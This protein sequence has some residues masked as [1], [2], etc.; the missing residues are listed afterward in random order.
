MPSVPLLPPRPCSFRPREISTV[1]WSAAKAGLE[2]SA[3]STWLLP[4]LQQA[5]Q[6]LPAFNPQDLS[7]VLWAVAT[8]SEAGYKSKG[9]P[10]STNGTSNS[11][12]ASTS[13][14]SPSHVAPTSEGPLRTTGG[15][16]LRLPPSFLSGLEREA[17]LKMAAFGSQVGGGAFENAPTYAFQTRCP[18]WLRK[19]S[20]RVALK[21]S[22]KEW[23][24]LMRQG[25][26]SIPSHTF[27]SKS[28]PTNLLE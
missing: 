1:L 27:S 22:R 10:S 23:S 26:F 4:L 7:M 13:Y 19:L 21:L 6:Q 28:F 3:C 5:T 2:P 18:G 9:G 24:S 14:S 20:P 15:Q 12:S 16:P 25:G 11:K 8:L 17:E